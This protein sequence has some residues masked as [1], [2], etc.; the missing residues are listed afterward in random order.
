MASGIYCIENLV[1]G[2]KYIGQSV[3]MFDR[4]NRHKYELNNNVHCNDSLQK[5]WTKYGEYNFRFYTL[6]ICDANHLDDKEI[7]YID[8]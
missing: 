6:E 4:W 7:Y 8:F 2:K 5:A 3:N 1:N